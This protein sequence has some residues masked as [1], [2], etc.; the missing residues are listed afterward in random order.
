MNPLAWLCLL[1]ASSS[2]VVLVDELYQIP[3]D[4]W[5]YVE[6]SLRQQPALLAADV[7]TQ[8]GSREIRAELVRRE[9]LDRL[10]D[11]RPHGVL[12]ATAPGPAGHIRYYLRDPG[13]YAVVVDN[14]G[15]DRGATVRLTVWLDFAADRGMSVTELSPR[16]Q[17]TVI[18]LSFAVF[19]GIVTW[20]T[21]RLLS[22]IRK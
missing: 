14:R 19:F 6:V 22:H 5:R 4:E 21:R 2:S 20:S 7:V 12:A 10:R 15:G 11:G 3:A 1:V 8:R 9:D 16:R 17:L 18:L 13:E